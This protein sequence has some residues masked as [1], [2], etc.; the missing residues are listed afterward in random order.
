MRPPPENVTAVEEVSVS[1][2]VDVPALKVRLVFVAVLQTVP[3]PV[4][5][6]V[7]DPREMARVFVLVDRIVVTVTL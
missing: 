6:T 2:I 4:K 7:L 3:V 1:L 5:V